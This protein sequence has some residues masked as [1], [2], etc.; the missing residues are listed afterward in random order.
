MKNLTL[1]LGL[2]LGGGLVY[3]AITSPVVG[4]ILLLVAGILGG[5]VVIGGTVLLVNHQWTR[6]I[7]QWQAPGAR[8][9][10]SYRHD[11][12]PQMGGQDMAQLSPPKDPWQN[13][14]V[15]ETGIQDDGGP[16]A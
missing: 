9:N 1:G 13:I 8:I 14:P 10:H 2:A 3:S 16:V 6:A 7:G 11:Y 5:A 15:I 12:W 4:L